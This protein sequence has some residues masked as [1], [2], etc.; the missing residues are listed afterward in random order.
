MVT[1]LARWQ[2]KP[3]FLENLLNVLPQLQ[4]ASMHEEGNISYEVFRDS[5]DETFFILLEKYEDE[6]A[7]EAHRLSDH[8]QSLVL[9]TIV[10][11]L[12]SRSVTKLI[13]YQ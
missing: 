4:Q 13:P 9:K 12:I 5:Q 8:F 6:N 2:V 11:M 1:I 3:E 10:P 7:L